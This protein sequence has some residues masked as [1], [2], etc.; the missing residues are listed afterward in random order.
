M[1]IPFRFAATA[2]SALWAIGAAYLLLMPGVVYQVFDLTG[3]TGADFVTR[4]AAAVFAGFS[5]ICG[6]CRNLEPGQGQRAVASGM[7]L[8]LM[9]LA[10]LGLWEYVRG[11][12][13]EGILAVVGL[14]MVLAIALLPHSRGGLAQGG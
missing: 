5:V 8:T 2:L 14:E 3:S 9:G 1:T 13:H 11:L 10:G 6:G 7:V 12:A 4:A